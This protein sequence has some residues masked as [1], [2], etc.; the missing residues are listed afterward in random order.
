[1]FN[2]LINW[3]S[4]AFYVLYLLLGFGL[5]AVIALLCYK[6]IPGLKVSKKNDDN[7]D[8]TRIAEEELNRILVPMDESN[9]LKDEKSDNDDT[10]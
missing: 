4:P 5:I 8:E 10:K 7:V 2:V 6:Y 3:N 9:V 1:M